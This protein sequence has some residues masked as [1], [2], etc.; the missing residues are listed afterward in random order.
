MS[1]EAHC[2]WGEGPDVIVSVNRE[3][4]SGFG[5]VYYGKPREDSSTTQRRCVGSFG[6]TASEARRL[7]EQL[8]IAAGQA[9][10]YSVDVRVMACDG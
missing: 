8:L 5:W 6:L 4:T 3:N 1:A 10:R 2:A 7:A 9:E